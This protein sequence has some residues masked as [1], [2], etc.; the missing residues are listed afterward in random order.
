LRTFVAICGAVLLAATLSAPLLGAQD[1]TADLRSRFQHETNPVQKAKL[2][3]DLGQAEFQQIR[4]E[5]E[6]YHF[7]AALDL[8][9]EY[10]AQVAVCVKALADTNVD[11]ERH[12]SG[13][14]QLQISVQESLRRIDAL[15]PPMTSDEQAPFL[16]I[17]KDLDEVN[18]H[19]IEQLFP[20]RTPAPKSDK[21]VQ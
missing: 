16:E 19:L 2:M 15:L 10:D 13:F 8:L 6:A 17:R 3:P 4:K 12:P 21:I 9:R 20:G 18:R 11:P 1:R 7:S 14:K 5:V